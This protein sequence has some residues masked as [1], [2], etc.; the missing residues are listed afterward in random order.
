MSDSTIIDYNHNGDGSDDYVI[1]GNTWTNKG[2]T[3][4]YDE[5]GTELLP[6]HTYVYTGESWVDV[7]SNYAD[8]V[9]APPRLEPMGTWIPSVVGETPTLYLKGSMVEYLGS[10]YTAKFD[11]T[12]NPATTP[13]V[14]M[15]MAKAGEVGEPARYVIVSGESVFIYSAG[16]RENWLAAPSDNRS[17]IT[18]TATLY[19][20]LTDYQ[21]ECK[22]HLGAWVT[23]A[24]ATTETYVVDCHYAGWITGL[25]PAQTLSFRCVSSGYTDSITISKL[26][27]GT[28]GTSPLH[29]QASPSNIVFA[30]SASGGIEAGITAKVN[31]K[32][33]VGSSADWDWAFTLEKTNVDNATMA[34][35]ADIAEWTLTASGMP[36]DK[37]VGSITVI[38]NKTGHAT[39]TLT[40]PV[41]KM[42]T[43]KD[44]TTLT[45]SPEAVLLPVYNTGM[46]KGVAPTVTVKVMEGTIDV[47]SVW[48]LT[49]S[50]SNNVG[51]DLVTTT[52][53]VTGLTNGV[54]TL[55]TIGDDFGFVEVT[56]TNAKGVAVSKRIS[57]TKVFDGLKGSDGGTS[58]RVYQ[59]DSASAVTQPSTPQTTTDGA[60]PTFWEPTPPEVTGTNRLW[61]SDAIYTPLSGVN[62]TVWGVPYLSVFKVD[63]LSAFTGNIGHLYSFPETGTVQQR[64]TINESVFGGPVDTHE[65]RAYSQYGLIGS[66]GD[67]GK[68]N[69]VIVASGLD[70]TYDPVFLANPFR[71]YYAKNK[72]GEAISSNTSG[73]HANII[74]PELGLLPTNT[75]H[76][77]VSIQTTD[78]A[79]GYS[80]KLSVEI[81]RVANIATTDG[82]AS[83][84]YGMTIANRGVRNNTTV[85]GVGAIK[86]VSTYTYLNYAAPTSNPN[87]ET[88]YAALFTDTNSVDATKREITF[89]DGS[90]TIKSSMGKN[91]FANGA[92]SVW[93]F[94]GTNTLSVVGSIAANGNVIAY[95]ASD[96]RLKKNIKP[97]TNA[98]DKVSKLSGNTFTWRKG[99]YSGQN[100]ELVKE[101]DVGVIAQEV[102]AVLPEAV[103]ERETGILA[104][105]YQKIIPLLIEAI[106]DLKVE[107][108]ELRN[109]ITN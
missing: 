33:Y 82:T 88:G 106:K 47:T 20:G 96:K 11:T 64:L 101:Q 34:L 13:G 19:G 107:V 103:Y 98:L 74:S 80:P 73:Y 7:S 28:D 77:G 30:A 59:L 18:L 109:G 67:M 32:M 36:T 39:Q 41:T 26:Y 16:Q 35:N 43:G 57:V 53:A 83:Y 68:N 12:S 1:P 93:M 40:I 25:T 55:T 21:W 94:N 58:K 31:I 70:Y 66:M 89:C 9:D 90:Y 27:D 37:D 85:S 63:T 50:V 69:T 102:Q 10:S 8:I 61:Q 49:K 104:V 105:D 95:N 65:F 86:G 14:W 52:D 56:A 23:I 51:A 76:T 48:A 44:A 4:Q 24:A 75:A 60:T 46:L 5:N 71:A 54:V 81:G 72:R 99:Y 100:K 78:E 79:G 91:Y 108:Q 84:T 22:N 62:N 3:V 2:T 42:R 38:A 6:D 87:L 15:L 45:F 92:E 17:T 29:L 97:I